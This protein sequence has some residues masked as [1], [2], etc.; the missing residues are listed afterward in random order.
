MGNCGNENFNLKNKKIEETIII[1]QVSLTVYSTLVLRELLNNFYMLV[2]SI[3]ISCLSSKF[4]F[5]LKLAIPMIFFLQDLL[6][7]T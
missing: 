3:K 1:K 5:E 7:K 2:K 4:N 6:K